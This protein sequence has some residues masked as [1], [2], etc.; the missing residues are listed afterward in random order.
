MAG[1]EIKPAATRLARET[2]IG[3]VPEETN[4]YV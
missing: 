3:V 1:L 4:E 2:A